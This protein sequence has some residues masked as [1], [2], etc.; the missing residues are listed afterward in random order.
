MDKLL[1][2]VIADMAIFLEFSDESVVDGDA[3][4]EVMEQID[5]QL[6]L[7]S[8]STKSAL[9]LSFESIAEDYGDR[10][11]FVRSLSD[12]FGLN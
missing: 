9:M 1:A 6:Q 7:A 4:I 8:D 10:A 12:V 11:D 5:A 2:K 3:A